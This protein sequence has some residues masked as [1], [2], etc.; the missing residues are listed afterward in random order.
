MRAL[1]LLTVGLV[2][3]GGAVS[4]QGLTAGKDGVVLRD[5]K[6]YRGIGVN[7]FDA[8]TR[9]LEDGGDTSYRKG[10]ETLAAR[11]IPFARLNFSG[12]YP[13]NWRLYFDN[14]EEYFR[15]M[16]GVVKAAEET[17]IGLIPS[18]HFASAFVCDMVEEPQ[19]AWGNP[20][21]K[22]IAFM[23]DY[24]R[25][26]VT[27]YRDSRAVWAWEFANEFN[28]GVDLPNAAECRPPVA[29]EYGTAKSR[30]AADDLTHD[31]MIV[32]FREFG[33]AVREHDKTRLVTHGASLPR[34][35]AEHLRASRSWTPD[36]PEEFQ[37]NLTD[38]TPDPID[39]VS[40]HLYPFDKERFGRKDVP[41][42]ETLGLCMEACR[43]MGKPLFVGEFGA[44]DEQ[45]G[46]PERT[47]REFEDLV[48]AIEKCAV[49]LSAVWVFDFPY[50][51]GTCNITPDNNRSY[52]LDIIS[53]S[54]RRLASTPA[55]D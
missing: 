28:L 33:R 42:E 15:R 39:L 19:S 41:Y 21:S 16:D 36:S 6:P 51:E 11:G 26:V 37:K 50:Q 40:V 3:L 29:P 46:G 24:V 55:G 7:Y 10:F 9:T 20:D 5:G 27:R 47:R 30:S 43:R 8:F 35:S 12:F 52:M 44:T 4:A 38:F 25:E 22:T 31:M 17:G 54:N 14:R 2:C 48:R 23:R 1:A 34:P 45:T 53:E 18:V 32:A 13:V 49:P